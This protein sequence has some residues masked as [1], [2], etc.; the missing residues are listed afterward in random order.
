VGSNP[1]LGT[2][3]RRSFS[4]NDLLN[5]S[6]VSDTVQPELRNPFERLEARTGFRACFNKQNTSLESRLCDSGWGSSIK[7]TVLEEIK[8]RLL[9]GSRQILRAQGDE[10]ASEPQAVAVI[11]RKF[12]GLKTR[13]SLLPML[14]VF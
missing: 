11:V 9:L 4:E 2:T 3:S 12:E 1:I 10:R 6:R 5:F 7:F 8:V 14:A 13:F